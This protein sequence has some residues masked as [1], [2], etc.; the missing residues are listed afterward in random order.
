[1]AA[2]TF[3]DDLRAALDPVLVP[4]GFASGQGEGP[5]V[6]FCASYDVLAD[7]HPRLPQ[8]GEQPSGIGACLDLVVTDDGLGHA[9]FRLEGWSLGDS[10]R[11]VGLDEQAAGAE[12]AQQRD[13]TDALD[14]VASAL[15]DL[16]TLGA[17]AGTG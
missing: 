8:I 14:A 16:L 12:L 4:R 2:S 11:H 1:M 10:L 9:T 13:L 7:R 3:A 6:I 15:E 17:D 5:Q